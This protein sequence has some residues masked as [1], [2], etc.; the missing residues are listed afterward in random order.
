VGAGESRRPGRDAW[1]PPR[2]GLGAHGVGAV[3]DKESRG[4]RNRRGRRFSA[5]VA[6]RRPG[7]WAPCRGAGERAREVWVRRSGAEQVGV[8]VRVRVKGERGTGVRL[9]GG[10]KV[11]AAQAEREAARGQLGLSRSLGLCR[12]R[13]VL[14]GEQGRPGLLVLAQGKLVA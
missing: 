12:A 13:L 2:L 10:P 6:A 5:V 8:G 11:P 4:Q 7:G 9:T 3:A 14:R 1:R